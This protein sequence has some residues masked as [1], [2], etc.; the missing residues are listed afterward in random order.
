MKQCLRDG[1]SLGRLGGD[2]FVAVLP[3]LHDIEA[4]VPMLTR[5]LEAAAQPV[6]FGEQLLQVSASL[7]V[8]FYPQANDIDADQLLRQADQAMYQ[9]KLAGKNRYH[10]FDAEQ[11]RSLRGHHE[12]LERIRLALS[13][14]EFMLYYQPKVN[15]RTGAVI[16]VEALIRWQHPQQGLLSPAA[17]LP[18]I[19]DHPLA[20]ELGEWVIANALYMM[21]VCVSFWVL[22]RFILRLSNTRFI[23]SSSIFLIYFVTFSG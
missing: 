7:G 3:D 14:G 6:Q 18:V 22:L 16:G 4:S 9:A 20:I 13:A 5:V 17:F 11:D 10:L 12:S 1:D 2:E 23:V 19:E 21:L 8:T 15:M